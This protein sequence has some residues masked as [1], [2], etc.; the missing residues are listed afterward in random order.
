M[1]TLKRYAAAAAFLSMCASAAFLVSPA[2]ADGSGWF[3]MDGKKYCADENGALLT[4]ERLIDGV[5]YLF[6]PN[7]ALQTGWQTVNGNRCYYD[8]DGNA[9]FGWMEWRGE[10]YYIDR[11][12]GKQ[13]NLSNAPFSGEE[14]TAYFDDCGIAAFGWFTPD[15]SGLR[16]YADET[17]A[18][19]CGTEE[20][21]GVPYVF[22][23]NGYYQLTGCQACADGITRY[24][25]TETGELQT[26]WIASY[27]QYRYADTE[28]G[29][30]MGEQTVD[31][32]PYRFSEDGV[33]QSGFQTFSDGTTRFYT[34]EPEGMQTGW[35]GNT[36]FG[37]AYYFDE[38][39]V[40]AVGQNVE[41]GGKKYA[42]SAD[43]TA[44]DAQT[45]YASDDPQYG[46]LLTG[47]VTDGDKTYYYGEYGE[48]GA[49]YGAMQTGW[50]RIGGETYHFAE[51]GVM[52]AGRK[53]V[54]GKLYDF[55]EDGRMLTGWF[56]E[57][58]ELYYHDA[59]TGAAVTG[60]YEID[61]KSYYFD[62]DYVMQSGGL[63]TAKSGKKYLLDDDGVMT[64]GVA[65]LDEKPYLFGDD[66]TMQFGF[67]SSLGKPYYCNADG[68]ITKGK[69]T[70]S[71]K[72]Y[73]VG[74]DY[75]LLTCW[76][77]M[78]GKE[79]FFGW[80]GAMVTGTTEI[81]GYTYKFNKSGVY[82]GADFGFTDEQDKLVKKAEKS[83]AE[84]PV[85]DITIWDNGE[86]YCL[87]RT[88]FP[89]KKYSLVPGFTLTDSDIET[90]E[91]FAAEH[92]APSMTMTQKLWI[93]LQWIHKQVTYAYDYP[94]EV[95]MTTYVDTIFNNKLGQ[96]LQYNGAMASVLAYFGFDV[97]MCKGHTWSA[98]KNKKGGQ[99]F[100]TEVLIDGKR[101]YLETGNFGKNGT[102]QYFFKLADC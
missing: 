55:T 36:W 29:V 84:E 85:R 42:F 71:G 94:P 79:Y 83:L 60:K 67:A 35:M 13:T 51:D 50:Q 75:A 3:T 34:G 46:R 45:E 2:A 16:Y 96:C 70:D 93:T 37:G 99:H 38:N 28:R 65:M 95:Y 10:R 63:Y 61:G 91:R 48:I 43:R 69:F 102:W 89:T 7:G 98:K 11:E 90:I 32:V 52:D 59:E 27:G 14:K 76:Q 21:G 17:G 57:D 26:G 64:F 25:D 24:Y 49:E 72:T 82:L 47:F 74:D 15:G 19:A 30:L 41:I 20:I 73:I 18:M 81:N 39:G 12:D 62:E 80:D 6:A 1:N 53:T 86:D 22:D 88:E 68:T 100:W 8:A 5:W 33:L 101:Y 87:H 78:D 66:G 54:D 77:V 56:R 40:M 31:G 97:Y 44:P 4:G 92:F 9:V 58:G 23:E